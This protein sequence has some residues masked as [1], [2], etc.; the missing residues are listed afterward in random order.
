MLKNVH[1]FPGYILRETLSP[2]FCSVTCFYGRPIAL[3]LYQTAWE[4]WI[5]AQTSSGVCWRRICLH[6]TETFR[7]L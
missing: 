3:E 6:C 4:I 5:L 7:I 1:I 2:Y